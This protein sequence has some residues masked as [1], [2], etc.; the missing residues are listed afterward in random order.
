MSTD[1]I[2]FGIY[3]GISGYYLEDY[4]SKNLVIFGNDHN[5]NINLAQALAKSNLFSYQI[6]V[7]NDLDLL[8][9]IETEVLLTDDVVEKTC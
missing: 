2:R 7:I 4:R 9:E 3:L 8:S 5:Y 6:K 1:K